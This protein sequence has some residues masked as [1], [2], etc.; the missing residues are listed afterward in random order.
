FGVP[1][2]WRAIPSGGFTH[3]A[4]QGDRGI[5]WRL[6]LLALAGPA[7]N[8]AV[9][10]AVW[11]WLPE[12][13]DGPAWRTPGVAVA[14]CW[15]GANAFIAV[16]S[17]LP[18]RQRSGIG[19]TPTD[20]LLALT[21][22]FAGP[23]AIDRW[24]AARFQLEAGRL[25]EQRRFAEALQVVRDGLTLLP[26]DENLQ[27]LLGVVLVDVGRTEEARELFLAQL[28]GESPDLARALTLNNVAWCDFL[29]GRDER[30][31]EAEA[32]SEE[33]LRLLPWFPAVQSTRGAVLVWSGRAEEALPLLQRAFEGVE[34]AAPRASVACVRALG[35]RQLGRTD[36]AKQALELAQTLDPACPLLQRVN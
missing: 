29:S 24:R 21:A 14:A 6:A 32:C 10:A 33:A 7:V 11:P 5:R 15:A 28:E 3:A 31:E 2:E 8:A 9:A 35:L 13:T 25:C 26:D 23:D 12:L 30:L 20:G 17:V 16:T 1:V 4:P 27:S 19:P 22:L 34:Q 18:Y 36:Q